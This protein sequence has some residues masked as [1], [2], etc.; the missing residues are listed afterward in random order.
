MMD[1]RNYL[2][3][4]SAAASGVALAGCSGESGDSGGSSDDS[5]SG[6][7]GGSSST[8]CD[9]SKIGANGG[10]RW[11]GV[12]NGTFEITSVDL[13]LINTE[14][15]P[16]SVTATLL[17]TG[18]GGATD[19]EATPSVSALLDGGESR[20]FEITRTGFDAQS[21]DVGLSESCP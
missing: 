20:E 14:D 5:S 6:N 9:P 4:F 18:E 3:T 17:F 16:I 21:W 7:G 1:R 2:A 19:V 15:F 12:A 13:T 10:V 11:E 8:G